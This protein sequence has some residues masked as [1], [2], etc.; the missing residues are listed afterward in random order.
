MT[1]SIYRLVVAFLISPILLINSSCETVM[2][3]K[4]AAI[5]AALGTGIGAGVGAALGKK[6]GALIG[7]GVGLVSGA[8][9]GHYIAKQERTR[10][11]TTA[12]VGYRPEQGNV[13]TISEATAAP[14]VAQKGDRVKVSFKYTI[15][16]PDEEQAQVKETHEV[17]YN[18]SPV[19]TLPNNQSLDQGEQRITW[20]YPVKP[21][22]QAGTYQILT[23]AQVE[24]KQAASIVTFTV[25]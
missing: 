23:T 8:L 12:A 2:Q 19:E 4:E 21:D 24:E 18:G 16:R 7:A 20:E 15:L 1:T 9:I 17:R 3:N 25:R 13:L 6:Q 11:Q 14:T 5:G 22:A 10:T